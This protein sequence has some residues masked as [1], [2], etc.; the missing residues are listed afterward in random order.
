MSGFHLLSFHPWPSQVLLELLHESH[1]LCI[2]KSVFGKLHLV[3]NIKDRK[4]E[5]WNSRLNS[6]SLGTATTSSTITDWAPRTTQKSPP[7]L[8]FQIIFLSVFL[9]SPK[10]ITQVKILKVKINPSFLKLRKLRARKLK[11]LAQIQRINF[12]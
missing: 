8:K 4:W 11:L 1:N 12:V 10:I 7:T 2:Q 9:D 6:F 3:I 5:I